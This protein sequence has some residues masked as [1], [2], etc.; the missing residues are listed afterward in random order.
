MTEKGKCYVWKM[1]GMFGKV[2][3]ESFRHNMVKI[4]IISGTA[5]VSYIIGYCRV[6]KDVCSSSSQFQV[7]GV[8]LDM[9]MSLVCIK[10]TFLGCLDTRP[11]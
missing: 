11:F 10:M 7:S 8:I 9:E 3:A 4:P 1:F 2:E 6:N 5:E